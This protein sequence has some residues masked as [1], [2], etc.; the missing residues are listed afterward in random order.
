MYVQPP[1]Q[2]L[3]LWTR[4]FN[5]MLQLPNS[6]PESHHPW[7]T[8]NTQFYWHHW[9]VQFPLMTQ[10]CQAQF[11][12]PWNTDSVGDNLVQ[13]RNKLWIILKCLEGCLVAGT[14]HT[15]RE[16]FRFTLLLCHCCL[17]F[18]WL[19]YLPHISL[20]KLNKEDAFCTVG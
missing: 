10:F 18:T 9:P 3:K 6:S 7:D 4:V 20:G 12:T 16:I 17:N 1:H 2:Y 5:G 19:V 11:K 15:R 8:H 13:L 14:D